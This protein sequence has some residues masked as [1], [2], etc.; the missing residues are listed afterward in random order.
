MTTD[1]SLTFRLRASIAV[2]YWRRCL[3]DWAA[4]FLEELRASSDEE[5]PPIPPHVQVVLPTSAQRR[6][7]CNVCAQTLCRFD[8]CFNT[9]GRKCEADA[10][11]SVT[12]NVWRPSRQSRVIKSAIAGDM[13]G[14]APAIKTRS[15]PL[16]RFFAFSF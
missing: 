2:D 14:A 3:R 10:R 7:L 12:V 6:P 5:R 8:L 15:F 1:K 16:I 4:A 11:L 9:E 13:P